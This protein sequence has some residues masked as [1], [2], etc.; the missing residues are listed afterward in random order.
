MRTAHTLSLLTLLLVSTFLTACGGVSVGGNTLPTG[1][2][3][4]SS[5]PT[6]SPYWHAPSVGSIN[7]LGYLKVTQIASGNVEILT[8]MIT[9]AQGALKCTAASWNGDS[10]QLKLQYLTDSTTVNLTIGIEATSFGFSATISA[11]Q[12]TITNVDFGS[13]ESAL[14]T[15]PIPVP[16]YTSQV[17]YS[18]TLGQYLNAWWDWHST[19]ASSLT[20]SIAQYRTKTDGTLNVLQET[21]QVEVSKNIDDVLPFPGNTP[22]PYMATM[23]GRLVLDIWD[24][25]FEEIQQNLAQLNDYGITNCAAVIHNWQHAGYD[26]ALPEHYSANPTLGGDD[27]MQGVISQGKQNGCLMALHENYIDYYPNYPG[28]TT[29]AVAL[30]NDGSNMSCWYNPST[31][32]Q[33]VCTKPQMMVAN[34]MTQSPEIHLNYGSNADYLDVHSAAPIS[35]HGDFDSSSPNAAKLTNW[36]KNNQ[37]L[38]AYERQTHQGPVLGEGLDHWYYSG[39]LDGVEAQLGAGMTGQNLDVSLPLFVDFDLLRIHPLQVNHGMGY[40]GRW[41]ATKTNAMSTAQQDAYR[42]QEIAFGHAPFLSNGKWSS[43]PDALIESNLV[44]PVATAYGTASATSIQYAMNGSWVNSAQAAPTSTFSQVQV[45]YNN[46]L[47]IVANSASH[48]ITWNNLSIPQ[49]GWAALS[50]NLIA[51]TATCGTSVCDFAKTQTS[52]FANARNQTDLQAGTGYA[53]PSLAS[54]RSTSPSQVVANF[55]WTALQNLSPKTAYKVFVHFVDDNQVTP[56][57]AGIV[58]QGDHWPTTSTTQWTMGQQVLDGPQPIGIP[59][60]VPDGTYSI[61]IGLFDPASGYRLQLAG[62]NDG[63]ERYIV[64]YVTISGKGPSVIFAPPSPPTADPRLNA[65]GHLVDFGSVRTDGMVSLNQQ[66]G[67]WVLRIFPRYRNVTVQLNS[68]DYP[69]PSI[70]ESSGGSAS[71]I[72]PTNAGGYWTIPTNGSKFYSWPVS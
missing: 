46:G 18:K 52:L 48:A 17:W 25:G 1:S 65:D 63:T 39:L 19:N 20:G 16:Y 70:V 26:N 64:G 15:T 29:S 56:N 34:A 67:M 60:S 30:K 59:G 24:S 6:G 37:A 42:T 14:N 2:G 12:P 5:P 69:M 10:T 57:N 9:S 58:F 68:S 72:E 53:S 44:S 22:S 40:Y 4:T 49:Y 13:W 8:P 55:N 41:T 54:L 21:L 71:S 38:W 27:G 51:Y 43:I 33:S 66:D 50:P 32:I 23:A 35:S 47:T 36:T 7:S 45:Q 62:N 28:Y 31:G 11:D 61:R 3:G